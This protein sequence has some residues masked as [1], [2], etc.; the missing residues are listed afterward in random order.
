M[1]GSEA[2]AGVLAG[3]DL[4][5]MP[6][7]LQACPWDGHRARGCRL[8]CTRAR[9][10]LCT[11][12]PSPLDPAGLVAGSGVRVSGRQVCALAIYG[13]QDAMLPEADL[14]PKF[15]K[16]A[17]KVRFPGNGARPL[18]RSVPRAC[19]PC[20]RRGMAWRPFLSVGWFCARYED[21]PY[22]RVGSSLRCS[23]C[24]LR[25]WWVVEP[26]PQIAGSAY[27]TIG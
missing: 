10:S 9:G 4:L 26:P 19:V 22:G 5:R 25:P 24:L 27:P 18:S 2:Q 13:D 21:A 1:A 7:A 14:I 20:R 15:F 16:N 8:R 6:R 3:M 12:G 17:W 11:L 23:A